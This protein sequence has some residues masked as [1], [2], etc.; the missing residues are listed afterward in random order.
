MLLQSFLLLM[1]Q[2]RSDCKTINQ[3]F[4]AYNVDFA[5]NKSAINF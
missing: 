2:I 4:P 5:K 3:L 1:Y